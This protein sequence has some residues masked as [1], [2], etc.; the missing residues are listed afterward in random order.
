CGVH[1]FAIDLHLTS[2][3]RGVIQWALDVLTS[4]S[5]AMMALAN[6]ALNE[7]RLLLRPEEHRPRPRFV[8]DAQAI[9]GIPKIVPDFH[10]SGPISDCGDSFANLPTQVDFLVSRNWQFK[11]PLSDSH[12]FGSTITF[13][14]HLPSKMILD[15]IER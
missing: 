6:A 15:R 1:R 14:R 3:L 5:R 12:A 9:K 7:N 10:K 8:K 2:L 4:A 11:K 13:Q